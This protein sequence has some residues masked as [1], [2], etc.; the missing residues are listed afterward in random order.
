MIVTLDGQ[1]L[2]EQFPPQSTLGEVIDRVR[3][4]VADD[5]LIV[6]VSLDGRTCAEPELND[7]LAAPL[8]AESQVDLE[9]GSRGSVVADALRV[10]AGALT[11]AEQV[12]TEATAALHAGRT[13]EGVSR[14][15]EFARIWQGAVQTV[16]HGGRLVGSDWTGREHEGR[17]VAALLSEFHTA[18]ASLRDALE[19]HDM[20]GLADALHY[21]FPPLAAGWRSLLESLAAEYT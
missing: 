15:G 2:A 12:R 18:L 8:T 6:A 19:A 1:R 4:K 9:L 3:E 14:L 17:P 11:D 10:A 16:I 20:V 13:A 7:L 5:R 21:E